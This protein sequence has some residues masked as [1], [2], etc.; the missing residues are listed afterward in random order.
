MDWVVKVQE[1]EPE[2]QRG[3]PSEHDTGSAAGSD[4]LA[5][6]FSH[7]AREL[8]SQTDA[9]QTLEGIVQ[10]AVG[11]IPGVDE[12]SISVVLNRKTVTSEA[13]SGELARAVDELQNEA[14]QG[15]C[16]DTAYEHET[17]RAADLRTETRW[18]RFTE[19]AVKLGAGSMLSLQLY[20][21]GDDLGA[22]NLYSRTAGAFDD[23]S[24]HVGLLF[25]SHAAIAYAAVQD[26][27]G[28][29][30]SIQTRQLIGQ[31]QGILMERHRI[32][33]DA[34]FGLLVRASQ[35]NNVKLRD[36]AERLVNS[37]ELKV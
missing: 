11:L 1:Q 36:L 31:A 24:E 27:A 30:R 32:T 20:V 34:A 18:P 23:E 12:A 5:V 6:Q 26:K 8:Q 19:K 2:N 16:L 33:A 29:S 22:L 10:A 13:P 7:L 4:D 14:G 35:H 25:A 28:L 3:E 37:G 9:H 15:P 21:E 17:V